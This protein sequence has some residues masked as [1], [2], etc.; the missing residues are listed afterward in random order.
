MFTTYPLRTRGFPLPGYPGTRASHTNSRSSHL[1]PGEKK[2]ADNTNRTPTA[3]TSGSADNLVMPVP[4][5]NW[6]SLSVRGG[7]QS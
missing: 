3:G 1:V 6:Q 2:E 5:T 7:T 4:G